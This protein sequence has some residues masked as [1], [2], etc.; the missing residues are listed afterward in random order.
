MCTVFSL[1][2]KRY[3][4][5][6]NLVFH[7]SLSS[8]PIPYTLIFKAKATWIPNHVRVAC[9]HLALLREVIFVYLTIPK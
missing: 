9:L 2:L 6:Y 8:S 3:I 4:Y 1:E 5:L 7:F